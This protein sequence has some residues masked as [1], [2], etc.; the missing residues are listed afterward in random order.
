MRR[1]KYSGYVIIPEKKRIIVAYAELHGGSSTSVI[2]CE[3]VS[4]YSCELT[5]SYCSFKDLLYFVF[6]SFGLVQVAKCIC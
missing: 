1:N 3:M 4:G 5:V 6:V 2:T